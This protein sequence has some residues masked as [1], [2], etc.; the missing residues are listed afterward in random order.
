MA[1]KKGFEYYSKEEIDES[2][3]IYYATIGTTIEFDVPTDCFIEVEAL[4]GYN[5]GYGGATRTLN[6]T[7]TG[8]TELFNR[9]GGLSAGDTIGR[10]MFAKYLGSATEG[11]TVTVNTA[12]SGSSGGGQSGS[13]YV[14]V[15][16]YGLAQAQ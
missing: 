10:Q 8:A 14:L 2:L 13:N 4:T 5:W 7:V 1:T 3:H 12:I 6:I 15:K 16:V 9:P 11:S